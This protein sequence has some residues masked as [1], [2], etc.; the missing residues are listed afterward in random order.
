MLAKMEVAESTSLFHPFFL[1]KS[2][3]KM[4]T[5]QQAK[6]QTKITFGRIFCSKNNMSD[7]NRTKMV[8]YKSDLC[9][10]KTNLVVEKSE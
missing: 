5:K 8:P 6:K 1:S 9:L 2:W 4:T 10:G 3:E 7:K